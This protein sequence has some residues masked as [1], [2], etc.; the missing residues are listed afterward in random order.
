MRIALVAVLA[1]AA[2]WF[3]ALRPKPDSAATTP[4]PAPTAPGVAGLTRSIDKARAATAAANASVTKV[5]STAAATSNGTAGAAPA[6][7]TPS[8]AKSAAKSAAATSAS[9]NTG[10]KAAPSPTTAT[11]TPRAVVVTKPKP[12]AVVVTRPKAVVVKPA[13]PKAVVIARP[14]PKVVAVSPAA[15]LVAALAQHKVVVLMFGNSSSDSHAVAAAVKRL[16]R[17]HGK[18]VIRIANINQVGRYSVFTTDTPVSQ[19]PTVLVIGS[20]R[21]GR[22]IVGYT[23]TGELDQ[24]VADVLASK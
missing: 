4:T 20:S 7:A 23:Y 12:K 13:A 18:V 21:K 10:G 22:V 19:A 3:V 5:Q 14:K 17:R 8:A 11:A 6:A 2:V 9:A 1:L 16:P 15:P 24:A